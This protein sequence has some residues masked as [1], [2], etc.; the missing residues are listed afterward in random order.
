MGTVL[1]LATN[2]L[3]LGDKFVYSRQILLMGWFTSIMFVTI[4]RL[5]FSF[6]LG[7]LRKRGLDRS[8]VVVVGTGPTAAVVIDRLRSHRSLGYDVVGAIDAN[9]GKTVG[10]T[11]RK[12]PVLGSV[13]DLRSIVR[14]L[15]VSEVIVALSG[16]SE[17]DIRDVL[18]RLQDQTVSIKVY[19]DAFQLMTENE[20]S[21]GELSGLPLLS[22]KDVALRGWNR[23]LKRTFDVV[24]SLLILT[25]ISPVMLA[26]RPR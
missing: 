18:E 11:I 26:S 24:F 10:S 4:G 13:A 14:R 3:I 15:K 6:A 8:L 7:A 5:L 25:L 19:P 2:S 20:V 1:S 12:V 17:R 22:V 23:I 21:V 9:G 16:A